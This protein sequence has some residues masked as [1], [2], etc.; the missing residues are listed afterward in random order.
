MIDLDVYFRRIGDQIG[1]RLEAEKE[2]SGSS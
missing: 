2:R 1:E